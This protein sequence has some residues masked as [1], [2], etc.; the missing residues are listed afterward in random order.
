M[1]V[2][3]RPYPRVSGEK[4]A[5]TPH[6]TGLEPRV[7]GPNPRKPS[8]DLRKPAHIEPRKERC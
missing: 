1:N 6:V 8:S 7:P 2:G 4:W 3:G 5:A